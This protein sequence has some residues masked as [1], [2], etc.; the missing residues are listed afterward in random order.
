M[1]DDELEDPPDTSWIVMQEINDGPPVF[2]LLAFAWCV[3]MCVGALLLLF[4]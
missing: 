1:S 3:L 4:A 2:A